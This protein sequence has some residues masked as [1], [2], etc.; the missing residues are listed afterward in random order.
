MLSKDDRIRLMHMVDAAREAIGYTMGRTRED[1]ATDTML[2]RALV[3]CL[4]VIGEAAVRICPE[5][6]SRDDSIPWIQ[7]V[8]MR[9]RLIHAYF[10]I[11]HD[12]IWKAV[13]EDLP[14][15]ISRLQTIL[16]SGGGE[17]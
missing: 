12:E 3:N 6:R 16:N 15:L 10:D 4:A 2:T 13:K 5:T 1:L 17:G 7:I 14:T 11:D 9:N 8:G